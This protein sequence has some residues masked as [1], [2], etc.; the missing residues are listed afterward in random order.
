MASAMAS[1]HEKGKGGKPKAGV[2]VAD[3][4]AEAVAAAL[5][6]YA[7]EPERFYVFTVAEDVGVA[8]K[9][10]EYV[11][12]LGG[13]SGGSLEAW[14]DRSLLSKSG[15]LAIKISV[16]SRVLVRQVQQERPSPRQPRTGCDPCDQGNRPLPS[17][18]RAAE[19]ASGARQPPLPAG[20]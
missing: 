20:G 18:R 10:V 9:G 8:K 14:A 17:R 15:K 7:A 2:S 12:K 11:L 4:A 5:A 13:A 6:S 19:P 3:K 16:G 1:K